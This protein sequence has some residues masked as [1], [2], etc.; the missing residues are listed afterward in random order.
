MI[1]VQRWQK[2]GKGCVK[3]DWVEAGI[4]EEFS[5]AAL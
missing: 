5:I 4:K 2:P 3:V 1:I